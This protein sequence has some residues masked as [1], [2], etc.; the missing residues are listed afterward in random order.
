MVKYTIQENE[1]GNKTLTCSFAERLDTEYCAQFS[2]E[3]YGKVQQ[4]KLPVVFDLTRVDYIASAFLGMC[5]RIFKEVGK[6]NFALTNV[7]P[8]VKKVLMIAHVD[9]QITIR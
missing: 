6:E 2:D 7:T 4:E 8:N 3:I 9:K 1:S 5:F